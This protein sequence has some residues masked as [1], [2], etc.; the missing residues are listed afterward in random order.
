[1]SV[2]L[3]VSVFLSYVFSCVFCFV[4]ISRMIGCKIA[5]EITLELCRWAIVKLYSLTVPLYTFTMWAN[6]SLHADKLLLAGQFS[7]LSPCRNNAAPCFWD[8]LCANFCFAVADSGIFGQ[9]QKWSSRL[10]F[11]LLVTLLPRKNCSFKATYL[12]LLA[13]SWMCYQ[14]QNGSWNIMSAFLLGRLGQY[15]WFQWW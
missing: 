3:V 8:Y 7:V 14:S 13:V 10:R 4:T 12:I 9:K 11:G 1:M 6:I 2:P 15:I 5:S